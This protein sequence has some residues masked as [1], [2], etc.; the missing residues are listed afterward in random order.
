MDYKN[1]FKHYLSELG[2]KDEI[3]RWQEDD[4]QQLAEHIELLKKNVDIYNDRDLTDF[5]NK[6]ITTQASQ[7]NQQQ[8][9]FA[10]GYSV[11]DREEVSFVRE[12]EQIK[13]SLNV[14]EE[15]N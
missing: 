6:N 12:L 3:I 9:L 1:E 5:T 10:S 11:K 8:K 13:K 2:E 4:I 7:H 14:I 15:E